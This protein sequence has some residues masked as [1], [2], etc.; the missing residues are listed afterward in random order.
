[1]GRRGLYSRRLRALDERWSLPGKLLATAL[2]HPGPLLAV[3]RRGGRVTRDGRVLHR[4]VQALLELS[5]LLERSTTRGDGIPDPLET[6]DVFVATTRLAMPSRTDIHVN[7]RLIA[8]PE[9]APDLLVRIYRRFGV[10]IG[11]PDALPPAITYFHGG[12]WVIGNLDSHDGSCRLLAAVTGCVVVAVDYRLAPEHPFPA[13]IEDC[14]AAY[15]WVQRSHREL[16]TA[17]GRVGVMGDSAGGNLAAVV[18]LATRTGDVPAPVAQGLVYPAL[19]AR[20]DSPSI[21]EMGDGFLLTLAGMQAYRGHYLPDPADWETWRASP[22]LAEDK[23]GVAPALVVTAGFDP[24]RDD[25]SGYAADLEAVD[26]EVEYRCY[27]DMVHGFF[28][29]GVVP[30]CLA[31]ATEVCDAMGAL[32]RR[33]SAAADG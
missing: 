12:G 27:D 1:M 6:R 7:D 4:G 16:G 5:N 33:A 11:R 18:A 13:A 8:G 29:M 32:M 24:L 10:G 3:L 17:P 20:L 26:V 21:H 30:D 25:G 23:R 31:L 9:G 28:G 2:A 14:L 19:D 22:L 15:A